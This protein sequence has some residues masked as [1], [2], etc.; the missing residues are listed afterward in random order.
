[1][2]VSLPLVFLEDYEDIFSKR[3]RH[4]FTKSRSRVASSRRHRPAE[5][6]K[7]EFLNIF[8]YFDYS[9]RLV[10]DSFLAGDR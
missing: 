2:A 9:D 5:S 8:D 3:K 6:Q 10:P 4:L 1:M 7:C